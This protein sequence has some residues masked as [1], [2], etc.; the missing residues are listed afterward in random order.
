MTE[1]NDLEVLICPQCNNNTRL[2]YDEVSD[3]PELVEFLGVECTEC[4]WRD[5]D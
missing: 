1:N 5:Y 2:V 4:S 3:D